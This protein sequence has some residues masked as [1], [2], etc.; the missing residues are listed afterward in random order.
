VAR[1]HEDAAGVEAPFVR[2]DDPPAPAPSR[3]GSTLDD[4]VRS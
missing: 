4:E 1:E 3:G 2:M